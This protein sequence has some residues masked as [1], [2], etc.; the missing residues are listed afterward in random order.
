MKSLSQK[1]LKRNSDQGSL[2]HS[3]T[4]I[5]FNL[6]VKEPTANYNKPPLK[7]KTSFPSSPNDDV[8][9]NMP[10]TSSDLRKISFG[11][12][13]SSLERVPRSNSNNKYKPPIDSS[14]RQTNSLLNLGNNNNAGNS[15][16]GPS[17]DKVVNNININFFNN[18]VNNN[19]PSQV[20]ES[21]F[22]DN[23]YS[24]NNSPNIET[25]KKGS[26]LKKTSV[27]IQTPSFN[28]GGMGINMNKQSPMTIDTKR[29]HFSINT[30]SQQ[31]YVQD[32]RTLDHQQYSHRTKQPQTPQVP[33]HQPAQHKH[34]RQHEKPY[35]DHLTKQE[36]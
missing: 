35:T 9:Y 36:T 7:M 29:N 21:P 1:S 20:V 24:G 31:R 32:P 5:N 26:I 8:R 22:F 34:L 27:D 11:K 25:R 18:V 16:R 3:K 13:D 33:R 12:K 10:K 4:E 2:K 15:N 23:K 6:P 14:M 19:Y 17:P 30:Y 28:I